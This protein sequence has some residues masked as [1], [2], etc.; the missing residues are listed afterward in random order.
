M[1]EHNA[2]KNIVYPAFGFFIGHAI[3]LGLSDKW[4]E[5]TK[6]PL[7]CLGLVIGFIAAPIG[8]N[9][10]EKFRTGKFK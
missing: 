1:E 10:A 6:L 9:Y 8:G 5:K 2:L 3:S 7:T 4:H